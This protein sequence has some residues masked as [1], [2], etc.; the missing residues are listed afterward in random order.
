MA[1]MNYFDSNMSTST[2]TV[3]HFKERRRLMFID[4]R[5]VAHSMY[6]AQLSVL[7]STLSNSA[8]SFVCPS[9]LL[10]SCHIPYSVRDGDLPWVHVN[11]NSRNMLQ[12]DSKWF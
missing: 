8:K 7:C 4:A 9:D 10:L 5:K 12:Y 6:V 2:N 1:F 3:V 11:D